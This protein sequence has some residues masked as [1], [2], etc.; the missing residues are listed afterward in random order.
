MFKVHAVKYCLPFKGYTSK[1]ISV[2]GL[3]KA[4]YRAL[5]RL[6]KTWK[7]RVEVLDDTFT[8]D[9]GMEE[10]KL[11]KGSQSELPSWLIEVLEPEG[12]V[13]QIPVTIEEISKYLYQEKQNATVPGSLVQ[14]PW[15]FYMRAR[16]TLKKL[17]GSSSPSDLENYRRLSYMVNELQRLR[18]RK[19]VQLASLNVFD[20]TLINKM[21]PEENL[22]FQDLRLSLTL[23]GEG[24]GDSA[25]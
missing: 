8:I 22:V 25:V 3:I 11:A 20:Q 15:D 16:Y 24:D 10:V 1:C 13:S 14:I 19:I 12:Y 18:I 17:S 21:T 2:V 23:I 4:K 7:R 5:G 6:V 9:L